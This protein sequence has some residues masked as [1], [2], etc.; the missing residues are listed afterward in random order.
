[1]KEI[2]ELKHKDFILNVDYNPLELDLSVWDNYLDLLCQDRYYQKEA[3]KTAVNY[4]AGKK[5]D[6]LK[7]LARKNFDKNQYI[8]EAYFNEKDYINQLGLL[9]NKLFANIDLATATGKS[10]VMYGI[11]QILLSIGIVKKVLILCPSITIEDGLFDKFLKLSSNNELFNLIPEQYIKIRPSIIN[12]NST[13]LDGSICIENIHSV[14]D[15]TGSSI[16]DSLKND[17]G[18]DTLILN[19]ESHHIFNN[20]KNSDLK[21]W[22]DFLLNS[23]YNFKYI[24]GFTGTAYHNDD[25]FKNVIYRYS[26][27]QAIEDG[28][29]KNIEYISES[30][31][32]LKKEDEK[33]QII[34]QKHESNKLLYRDILKPI[35]IM[36]TKDIESA[37]SLEKRFKSFLIKQ[38]S[39]NLESNISLISEEINEKILVINYTSNL[40]EKELL[41]SIDSIENKVEWVISVSMLNEGWDVKNVFQIIPMEEKAFNSKLLIA[42]VLGR[43][44]RK[45][46]VL[47]NPK[48]FIMNHDSWSKNIKHLVN[49][50]LEI[51]TKIEINNSESRKK[52]HFDLFNIDYDKEPYEINKKNSE[53]NTDKNYNYSKLFNDGV[54]LDAQAPIK[55]IV[56]ELE[57]IKLNSFE[58]KDYKIKVHT[59]TIDEVIN[60]IYTEFNQRNWEGVVLKIGNDLYTKEEQPPKYLVKEMIIKS[61]EPRGININQIEEK[62]VQRILSSFTTILRKSNKKV[63]YKTIYN[64]PFITNTSS[65][66]KENIGL[67]NFR[68]TEYSLFLSSDYKEDVFSAGQKEIISYF[69]E[70][71][72]YPKSSSKI[73]KE[74]LFKTPYNFVV[75]VSLPEKRF[76]EELTKLDV[77]KKI[78]SWI[79]S[80]NKGLY[81]IDYS[82]KA[83]GEN[84]KNRE[85]KVQSFNPDF[86]IKVIKNDYTYI[87][88]NEIKADK[89]I[90]LENRA[91]YK[92]AKKHF[93]ILN[94]KLLIDNQK[95]IYI[96]HMLSPES[97]SA[98]FEWLKDG[99]LFNKN[100]TFKCELENLL[101]E[102]NL[103]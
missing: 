2:I 49:E 39:S 24:L 22:G 29:V 40:K 64:S 25:Y 42:Q 33:F 17:K 46:E 72:S 71:E 32:M 11:S 50:I 48:V 56:F 6:S 58:K 45:P 98:Y 47:S 87:L 37:V 73:I 101:E 44:L 43:G 12:A 102:Q 88:V 35:S 59:W 26:L 27:K 57:N 7:D 100:L 41:K 75:S 62:N 52:Y 8:K 74:E 20:Q 89:D 34:L 21:K 70:D 51:E 54:S 91:K 5:Y 68:R 1:M 28:F 85:Y 90:C 13:I 55:N 92:Y 14:Y 95:T 53:E 30:S 31:E 36:I 61:L 67:S 23:D 82:I 9:A 3:I 18:K 77:A 69:I 96:F 81:S 76:I 65:A 38:Y 83:G 94:E 16:K 86:F 99:R 80:K 15:K 78:D 10:F 19:D 66:K 103:S 63:E 4:I 84:S 97:Y 93:E 79:K 60:K